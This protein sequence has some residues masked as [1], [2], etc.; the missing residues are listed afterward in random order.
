MKIATSTSDSMQTRPG[1]PLQDPRSDWEGAKEHGDVMMREGDFVGAAQRYREAIVVNPEF[2]K[3]H[4]NL[5]FCLKENGQFREAEHALLRALELDPAITDAHYMLGTLYQASENG[6]DADVHFRAALHLDPASEFVLLD[7]SRFLFEQGKFNDA[8]CVLADGV[9]RHPASAPMHYYLGNIY[10]ALNLLDLA[11]SSF[12]RALAILP[13]QPE[14]LA[15]LGLALLKQENLEASI[16]ALQKAVHF[17]PNDLDVFNNLGN[18]FLKKNT[19]KE[20]MAS[21]ESGLAINPRSERLRYN[22]SLLSLLLGEF[23]S[24]WKDYECR[25]TQIEEGPRHN[26]S[27]PL[28]LND[29]DISG[30]T[31][32]LH[33]EQGI[34][35]TLQFIRY[36]EQVAS[37]AAKV[38]LEV[39][40]PLQSLTAQLSGIANV[41]AMGDP[42]PDFDFHCP[43]ASLPLAFDTGFDN[44]PSKFPYL[45]ASPE[46]IA[47]WANRLPE[48]KSPRIGLVWAGGTFF[49]NDHHRSIAFDLFSLIATTENLCFF[50]LQRDLRPG[51]ESSLNMASCISQLGPELSDFSE[52]AAVVANLDL[53]ITVD[54]A[55]AHLAGAMGKP[56]WILLPFAPDFRWLLA[57]EDSPWYPSARLFRQSAIGNWIQI[58]HDVKDALGQ[59]FGTR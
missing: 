11:V 22:K 51:D 55:V 47:Y 40:V 3:A 33:A 6:D 59:E 52:T 16:A 25:W 54:T 18:A 37:L 48:T 23:S 36:V 44:I 57:R 39:H 12:N 56:V 53:I 19:L 50:S 21:Y 26:F 27:Q 14:M 1:K 43:L 41:L 35:D 31:I 17:N 20:A 13:E 38:Y 7:F 30:K 8:R 32:L 4:S 29:A 15:N 49:K 58:I 34:G 42:L 2:A 28:W 5:G 46:R 9:A 24:A 10:Y 45:A